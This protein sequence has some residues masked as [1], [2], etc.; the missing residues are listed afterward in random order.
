ML[1]RYNLF[2]RHIHFSPALWYICVSSLCVSSAWRAHKITSII[3]GGMDFRIACIN[4]LAVESIGTGEATNVL[5]A[6]SIKRDKKC[7]NAP[8]VTS[9]TI[10]PQS[11]SFLRMAEWK[12]C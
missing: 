4:G 6:K 10:A 3:S 2:Y 9:E 12:N 1:S 11:F 5:E 8:P 7:N